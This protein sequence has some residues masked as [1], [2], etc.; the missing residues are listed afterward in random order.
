MENETRAFGEES[1]LRSKKGHV[2]N[3]SVSPRIEEMRRLKSSVMMERD[4]PSSL[5]VTNSNFQVK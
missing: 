1:I 2:S 4:V 5:N 3:M